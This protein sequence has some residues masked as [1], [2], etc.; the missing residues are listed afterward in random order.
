MCFLATFSAAVSIYR[1]AGK[2]HLFPLTAFS[3]LIHYLMQKAHLQVATCRRLTA[4]KKPMQCHRAKI[5][6]K[7][8]L[9]RLQTVTPEFLR[10]EKQR[11][12][13]KLRKEGDGQG[14]KFT[15]YIH[16]TW[17]SIPGEGGSIE[18]DDLTRDARTQHAEPALQGSAAPFQS[19]EGQR[20]APSC[21]GPGEEEVLGPHRMPV[22]VPVS[23]LV[24]G[25]SENKTDA[26]AQTHAAG[27]RDHETGTLTTDTALK[28]K[29]ILAHAVC[30]SAL[31]HVFLKEIAL[32]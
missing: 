3:R 5:P 28:S 19:G 24:S 17:T 1:Q 27:L 30:I 29:A 4:F 12:G 31:S 6:Q 7:A 2:P 18:A 15:T 20:N 16:G 22:C 26:V 32:V 10:K 13:K 23:P 14:S 21:T 25:F 11:H 9:R 8:V